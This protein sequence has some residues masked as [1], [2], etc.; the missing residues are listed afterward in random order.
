[1]ALWLAWLGACGSADA[2][3]P[4]RRRREPSTTAAAPYRADGACSTPLIC[5]VGSCHT[6]VV[7]SRYRRP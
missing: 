3:P 2:M 6:K 1:M 5:A 7:V 4:A